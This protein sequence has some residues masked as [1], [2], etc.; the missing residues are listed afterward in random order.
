MID[1]EG[2]NSH[3]HRFAHK[4]NTF[5]RPTQQDFKKMWFHTGRNHISMIVNQLTDYL[6][7]MAI[8]SLMSLML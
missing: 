3:L 6:R 7:M 5:S 1:I 2:K 8:T 4:I